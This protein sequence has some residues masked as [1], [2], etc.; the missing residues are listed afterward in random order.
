MK[1]P[2]SLARRSNRIEVEQL[3]LL[4]DMF[5]LPFGH[6][7][8]GMELLENLQ[9][10]LENAHFIQNCM[11]GEE[12]LANESAYH[13]WLRRHDSI[14]GLVNQLTLFYRIVI[15]APNKVSYFELLFLNNFLEPS[16]RNF[17]LY[18]GSTRSDV[19]N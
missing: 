2:T 19:C 18:L 7:K 12:N 1:K 5:Y 3:A 15:D 9:W 10:L 17:S 11:S 16:P 13:E 6:G 8:R 4:V 14:Q